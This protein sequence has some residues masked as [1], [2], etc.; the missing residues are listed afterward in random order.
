VTGDLTTALDLQKHPVNDLRGQ[1]AQTVLTLKMIFKYRDHVLL[2]MTAEND[3]E[4]ATHQQ[5]GNC[6]IVNKS[7]LGPRM[8]LVT[9][10]EWPTGRRS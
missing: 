5:N 1:G 6:L 9:K 7:G 8:R 2:T 4:G 10:E 3:R